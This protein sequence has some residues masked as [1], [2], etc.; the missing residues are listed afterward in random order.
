MKIKFQKFK[1]EIRIQKI[2]MSE[3]LEIYKFGGITEAAA[4]A[5]V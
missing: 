5:V 4:A 2:S 3:K 1:S